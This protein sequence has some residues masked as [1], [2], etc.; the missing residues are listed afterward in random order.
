MRIIH[1]GLTFGLGVTLGQEDTFTANAWP[2]KLFTTYCKDAVLMCM[3]KNEHKLFFWY[4]LLNGAHWPGWHYGVESGYPALVSFDI[5]NCLQLNRVLSSKKC[6]P[7]WL[8]VLID[9]LCAQQTWA[10]WT[11]ISP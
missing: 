6:I 11:T 9:G 8:G 10:L 3:L 2:G 4:R 1:F 5:D 7:S